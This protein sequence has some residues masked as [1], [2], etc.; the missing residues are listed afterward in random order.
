VKIRYTRQTLGDL[1]EIYDAIA[2]DNPPAAGRVIAQIEAEAGRL[3]EFPLLGR[4]GRVEETRELVIA[5]YP[6]ILAYRVEASEVQ[7]LSI[8]HSARDW[9]D[10]F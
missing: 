3:A 10:A 8:L 6:Y 9:P 2:A 7:V 1:V 4:A 5:R